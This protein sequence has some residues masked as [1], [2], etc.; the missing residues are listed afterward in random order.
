MQWGGYTGRHKSTNVYGLPGNESQETGASECH[1]ER[2]RATGVID[3][4]C[5]GAKKKMGVYL[6]VETHITQ[7][8]HILPTSVNGRAQTTK[9]YQRQAS[10]TPQ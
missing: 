9:P 7:M 10:T 8:E 1:T 4:M 6:D 2:K 5:P 3:G